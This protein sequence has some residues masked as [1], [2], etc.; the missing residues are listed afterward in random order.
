MRL[1][2]QEL[3][4]LK[5]DLS[6]RL[7]GRSFSVVNI[8]DQNMFLYITNLVGKIVFDILGIDEIQK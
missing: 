4:L 8:G 1:E 2:Q 7:T 5:D 3:F 6:G